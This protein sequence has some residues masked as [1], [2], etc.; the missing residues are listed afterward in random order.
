MARISPQTIAPLRSSVP[1][2]TRWKASRRLSRSAQCCGSRWSDDEKISSR[3]FDA[4]D[5]IHR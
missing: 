2:G 1:M 4:T 5:S 3:G